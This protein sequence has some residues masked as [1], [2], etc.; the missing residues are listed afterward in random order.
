MISLLLMGIIFFFYSKPYFK[1]KYRNYSS[2]SLYQG[3]K[4]ITFGE[5]KIWLPWL[6]GDYNGV[7]VNFEGYLFAKIYYYYG[8]RDPFT[9][10]MALGY[11]ELTSKKCSETDLGKQGYIINADLT[12]CNC[13]EMDDLLMGGDYSFEDYIYQIE[14]NIHLCKNGENY[15]ENNPNCTK[16]DDLRKEECYKYVEDR[17]DFVSLIDYTLY[18]LYYFQIHLSA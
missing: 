13:I 15:D 17:V 4:A 8:K 6:L 5:Q 12:R 3:Y 18:L 1:R 16:I 14:I 10:G 9:G 11:R 7:P 2:L